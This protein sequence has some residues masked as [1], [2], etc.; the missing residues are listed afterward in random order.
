MTTDDLDGILAALNHR[1]Q[2]VTYSA[3]AALLGRGMNLR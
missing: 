3:V 2:R 1:Q